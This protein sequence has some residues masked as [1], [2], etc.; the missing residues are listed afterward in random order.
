MYSLARIF[1]AQRLETQAQGACYACVDSIKS[2]HTSFTTLWSVYL[3][4]A[5]ILTMQLIWDISAE[6]EAFAHPILVSWS[7]R[8]HILARDTLAIALRALKRTFRFFGHSYTQFC[9]AFR[10][11][12]W[13]VLQEYLDRRSE[14][15]CTS[16]LVFFLRSKSTWFC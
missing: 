5:C 1:P 2:V 14:Q 3:T 4:L 13:Y 16:S 10:W 11:S 12:C 9:H 7:V 6:M 8:V 15:C